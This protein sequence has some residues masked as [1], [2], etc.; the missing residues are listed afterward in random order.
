VT[1][2]SATSGATIWYNTTG[3][4][5]GCSAS[6]CAG[7][8]QVTGAISVASSQILYA[9][10]TES[11]YTN[12]ATSSAAYTITITPPT[13]ATPTFSPVAGTYTAAQSVALA[14]GT[15]GAAIYYTTNGTNPTTSS[16]LYVA[17]ISIATT[18]TITAL[19]VK[20][21]YTNSAVASALYTINI[22]S[23]S[24]TITVGSTGKITISGTGSVTIKGCS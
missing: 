8:F 5:T 23:S 11:G 15:S 4:F 10:A 6:S 12:S 3:T 7:A 13:A 1:I 19:A 20:S 9:I 17:P 16:T 24:C 14:S 18:T 22:S 2:S 21:G